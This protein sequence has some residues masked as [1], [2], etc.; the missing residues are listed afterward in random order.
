MHGRGG[1]PIKNVVFGVFIVLLIYMTYLYNGSQNRLREAEMTGARYKREADDRVTEIQDLVKAKDKAQENWQNEKFELNNRIKSINQQH[2]LLQGQYKEIE[3]DLLKLKDDMTKMSQAHQDVLSQHSQEYQL[4]KQTKDNEISQL[5]DDLANLKRQKSDSDSQIQSLQES[6]IKTQ[7]ELESTKTEARNYFK[8][9]KEQHE[10]DVSINSNLMKSLNMLQKEKADLEIE[11][12]FL[13]QNQNAPKVHLNLSNDVP[14][15]QPAVQHQ[16]QQVG[17]LFDD[18]HQNAQS[19]NN[20]NVEHMQME[21]DNPFK[22]FENL[23]EKEKKVPTPLINI[24]GRE[25]GAG[26][27][28]PKVDVEEMNAQHQVI[29]P[30]Q[31]QGLANDDEQARNGQNSKDTG[32]RPDINPNDEQKVQILEPV[33]NPEKDKLKYDPG[34]EGIDEDKKDNDKDVRMDEEGDEERA[35]HK[36][37]LALGQIQGPQP[38]ADNANDNRI[39]GQQQAPL[40]NDNNERVDGKNGAGVE[41]Q[42]FGEEADEDAHGGDDQY[43]DAKQNRDADGLDQFAEND[44]AALE[45]AN[46]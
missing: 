23:S 19:N 44:N 18:S 39:N 27:D 2:S 1:F 41:N 29:A 31:H 40:L 10:K 24:L 33:L 45:R 11:L 16:A 28:K 13:K 34:L 37:P 22:Q 14:T 6:V 9:L 30:V 7:N 36:N 38:G 42:Y 26:T 43:R 35:E 25:G 21:K 46:E 32:K 12:R 8:Q 20:N 15:Q 3:A 17:S 5:K 4:L